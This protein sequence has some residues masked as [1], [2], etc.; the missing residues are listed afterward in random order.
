[1]I[2]TQSRGKLKGSAQI[3]LNQKIEAPVSTFSFQKKI[4]FRSCARFGFVIRSNSWFR[5]TF[6]K[7]ARINSPFV[8]RK[9]CYGGVQTAPADPRTFFS[10]LCHRENEF[11]IQ[12]RGEGAATEQFAALNKGSHAMS[13]RQLWK[14]PFVE[15]QA[16][17]TARFKFP[18]FR[19]I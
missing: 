11:R 10:S 16:L 18:R 19:L 3:P 6:L 15:L 7:R 2:V 1:M 12:I 13:M 14:F 9:V 5:K 17:I 4:P 8:D